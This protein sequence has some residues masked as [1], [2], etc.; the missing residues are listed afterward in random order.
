MSQGETIS[1]KSK[2]PNKWVHRGHP[3]IRALLGSPTQ[4]LT[5]HWPGLCPLDNRNCK[6]FWKI[7]LFLF[8]NWPWWRIKQ[9]GFNCRE[10][11]S[12]MDIGW[13]SS[14]VCSTGWCRVQVILENQGTWGEKSNKRT[15]NLR[16][17]ALLVVQSHT[18]MG[19]EDGRM[20][21][22]Y[23]SIQATDPVEKH[24]V[25]GDFTQIILADS[26][27]QLE[28]FLSCHCF[29]SSHSLTSHS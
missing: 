5:S 14:C 13:A 24:W 16:V 8:F 23:K 20:W 22:F 12:G 6:G 18:L 19:V 27:V 11:V 17:K 4:L 15:L 25:P 9:N 7:K 1:T 26:Q 3:L 2:R 28:C 21:K 10:K 29:P